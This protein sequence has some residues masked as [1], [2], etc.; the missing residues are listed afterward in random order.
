MVKPQINEFQF[1]KLIVFDLEKTAA[2]YRDVCGLVELAR[3]E[4]KIAGRSITEI[5]FK[6]T[7]GDSLMA[8]FMLLKFHD[9][10]KPS[11]SEVMLAYVTNDL[12]A[13]LKRVRAAGGTVA[14]D[15][16]VIAETG[17]KVAFVH[18]VEGH[19]I[20]ALEF[21]RARLEGL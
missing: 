11:N 20:E 16:R 18:D 14:E 2:F 1:T 6:G 3:V 17:T 21:P 19:L 15:V 12:V 7:D 4:E 8:A 13:F 10:P 5:V 9:A